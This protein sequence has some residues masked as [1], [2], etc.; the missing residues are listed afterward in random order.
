MR[1]WPLAWRGLASGWQAAALKAACHLIP[2]NL[3]RRPL[4][5]FLGRRVHRLSGIENGRGRAALGD[6]W[7]FRPVTSFVPGDLREGE[8]GKPPNGKKKQK[9]GAQKLTWRRWQNYVGDERR[10]RQRVFH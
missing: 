5:A 6:D 2:R 9:I 4:A 1:G 8:R 10:R 7:P 3:R